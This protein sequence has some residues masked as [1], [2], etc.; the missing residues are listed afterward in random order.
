MPSYCAAFSCT[1]LHG[2]CPD[3]VTFHRFP[4]D[5]NLRSQWAEAL[6]QEKQKGVLWQPG[7]GN[8]LCSDH[9]KPEDFDRTGQ[10]TRLRP[11]TVPSVRL[12]PSRSRRKTPPKRTTRN[13]TDGR[14]PA[15]DDPSSSSSPSSTQTEQTLDKTTSTSSVAL[16]HAY[17]LPDAKELKSR[18]EKSNLKRRQLHIE[19]K[20]TR[21]R[22]KRVQSSSKRLLDDLRDQN[23]ITEELK[24][25]LD[26]LGD[27][28]LDLFA[29]PAQ[30]YSEDQRDF[31]LQLHF[32]SPKA[33]EYLRSNAK[34]R[35]PLPHP[36]TLCRWI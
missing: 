2:K 13:S 26:S 10:T 29:N 25:K 33:Y 4:K 30:C 7:V 22:L 15:D 32:Y 35:I 19:L 16:D 20:N 3:G 11:N 36:K 23:L 5:D 34:F 17:Q 28:P 27:I 1:N 12:F 14:P 8:Y 21:D 31:A 18:L 6:N 24:A 9:F